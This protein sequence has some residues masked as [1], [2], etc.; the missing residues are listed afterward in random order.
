MHRDSRA[1]SLCD[2]LYAGR[3]PSPFA[4]C[5]CQGVTVLAAVERLT[6][7][8]DAR[9]RIGRFRRVITINAGLSGDGPLQ[10]VAIV[11][12]AIAWK[13]ANPPAIDRPAHI[14][15]GLVDLPLA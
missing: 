6:I 10:P 15:D 5:E 3:L 14:G 2:P 4:R 13:T 1:R 7:A 9:E 11:V 12:G 8:V